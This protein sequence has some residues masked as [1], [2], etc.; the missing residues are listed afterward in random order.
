MKK[1]WNIEQIEWPIDPAAYP[2]CNIAVYY[3]DGTVSR[4]Y[5]PDNKTT[6]VDKLVD[7]SYFVETINNANLPFRNKRKISRADITCYV[8]DSAGVWEKHKVGY[9][10]E[11]EIF[12]D[13]V[14]DTPDI[15]PD[16]SVLCEGHRDK[17][18]KTCG[19]IEVYEGYGFGYIGHIETANFDEDNAFLSKCDNISQI[20]KSGY[21][22]NISAMR[23]TEVTIKQSLWL[24][25][26]ADEAAKFDLKEIKEIFDGDD[27]DIIAVCKVPKKRARGR[28]AAL[29]LAMGKIINYFVGHDNFTPMTSD[30]TGT[31]FNVLDEKHIRVIDF[32]NGKAVETILIEIC[33]DE[34]ARYDRYEG[35]YNDRHTKIENYTSVHNSID[36]D[37][38]EIW[39]KPVLI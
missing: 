23:Y 6:S 24:K 17:I 16:I 34:R 26:D 28:R 25:D 32:E 22:I 27:Y 5:L 11:K 38:L 8:K 33:L 13:N 3:E 18:Y 1:L 2:L 39:Q 37:D 30:G 31:I 9:D 36:N 14:D 4:G 15:M 10:Y 35:C 29:E 19:H 20:I 12:F 7:E 21:R